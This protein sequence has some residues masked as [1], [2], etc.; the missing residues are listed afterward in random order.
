MRPA[1]LSKYAFEYEIEA[2]ITRGFRRRGAEGHAFTP[3]VAGGKN[4]CTIHHIKND[5]RL[6]SDE[7]LILDVGAMYQQYAADISRTYALHD[8]PSRRQEQIY[9]AVCEAQD[10]AYSLLKPGVI[11]NEYEKE[12]ESFIGEKLRELG[13]IKTITRETVRESGLFPHRVSH[14]LGIEAH[15]AGN[16]DEPLKPG[17][18][19]VAEPGIY[20]RDEGIGVRVEDDVLITEDGCSILSSKLPRQL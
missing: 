15:D 16:Y 11:L 6:T 9:E 20:I 4:A 3:I 12:M 8:R 10:Y 5:S 19:L 7:L 2:E 13:L 1:R 18:V 17:V 14:F